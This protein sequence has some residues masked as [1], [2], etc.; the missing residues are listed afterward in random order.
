MSIL[1]RGLHFLRGYRYAGVPRDRGFKLDKEAFVGPLGE[2][3]VNG[4]VKALFIAFFRRP[5]RC[6]LFKKAAIIIQMI[7]ICERFAEA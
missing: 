6:G 5:G 7:L 4:H 3:F 1:W 2:F